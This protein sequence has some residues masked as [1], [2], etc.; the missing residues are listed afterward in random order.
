MALLSVFTGSRTASVK[1]VDGRDLGSID[2]GVAVDLWKEKTAFLLGGGSWK[3]RN[4][5]P[6]TETLSVVPSMGGRALRWSGASGGLSFALCREMR[7]VLT[8]SEPVPFLGPRAQEVLASLRDEF[9]R[10]DSDHP[11]ARA[12]GRNKTVVETWAG[13]KVNS[14]L[15][16]ALGGWLGVDDS[17]TA[18]SLSL[19]CQE[20]ELR[21]LVARSEP[22]E[23]FLLSGL[24]ISDGSRPAAVSKFSELLPEEFRREVQLGE[25]YDLASAVTVLKEFTEL[26]TLERSVS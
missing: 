17:F 15:A 5:D 8:E 12:E 11:V 9:R 25:E 2:G 20:R 14:L 10:L 26:K 7:S 6:R 23:E 13:E 3:P 18:F 4:W 24:E 16:R 1:T 19:T 21:E 22:S